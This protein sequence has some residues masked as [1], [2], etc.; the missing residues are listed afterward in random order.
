[1]EG[2][3]GRPFQTVSGA[4]GFDALKRRSS[5]DTFTVLKWGPGTSHAVTV[6][7]VHDGRVYFRNPQGLRVKSGTE[8]DGSG[9]YPPRR[10][11]DSFR[12]LESMS[13]HEFKKRFSLIMVPK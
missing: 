2:L 3:Y 6:E 11:E 4:A 5:Q 9:G 12:D 10:M 13:E 1:M 8:I 7:S